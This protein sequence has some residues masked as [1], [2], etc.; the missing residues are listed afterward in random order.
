MTD[1]IPF[2]ESVTEVW[3]SM[4][5]FVTPV[6]PAIVEVIESPTAA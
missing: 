3:A 6:A 5:Y 4:A 1:K 2:T